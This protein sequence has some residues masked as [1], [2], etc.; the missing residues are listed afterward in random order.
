[1]E[2]N[3]KASSVKDC[4][5]RSRLSAKVNEILQ[6]LVELTKTQHEAFTSRDDAV[7]M[8]LDKTLELTIGRKERSIGALRQHQQEHG[9]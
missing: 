9:C 3:D 7:F 8:R 6:E 1:M 2:L 5:E 4:P